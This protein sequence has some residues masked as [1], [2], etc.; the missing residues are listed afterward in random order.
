MVYAKYEL[1][2]IDH[3]QVILEGW[4]LATFESPS[5]NGSMKEPKQLAAALEST[6]KDGPSCKFQ[7]LNDEEYAT[8]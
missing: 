1:D 3:Y 7:A 2:I 8:H 5:K 6:S 4:P